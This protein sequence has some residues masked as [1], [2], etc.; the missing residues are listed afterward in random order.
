MKAL[1]RPLDVVRSS[2]ESISTYYLQIH[3]KHQFLFLAQCVWK[4]LEYVLTFVHQSRLNSQ[5]YWGPMWLSYGSGCER[6]LEIH[7]KFEIISI[8][9][10]EWSWH[11]MIQGTW[12]RLSCQSTDSI[13]QQWCSTMEKLHWCYNLES[14]W[15]KW[16]QDSGQWII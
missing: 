1:K 9:F 13:Y 2:G 7:N 16:T 11:G 3:S 5:H 4:R 14:L 6:T 8:C 15:S 12:N 10:L